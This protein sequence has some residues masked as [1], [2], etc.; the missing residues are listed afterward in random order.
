MHLLC[1]F[2]DDIPNIEEIFQQK[3]ME[4]SD[5][6]YDLNS[7]PK[8]KEFREKVWNIHHQGQPMPNANM[9]EGLEDEDIIMS[10][11]RKE[12]LPIFW[13]SIFCK[14]FWEGIA[15]A[16]FPELEHC[17]MLLGKELYFH[18]AIFSRRG[19][20]W[21]SGDREVRMEL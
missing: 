21:I 14:K 20:L 19:I 16:S 4:A 13:S 5:K 2:S 15:A 10:Q 8:V 7:H 3:L 6:D 17:I 9:Q 1:S 18:N 12:T 11:V